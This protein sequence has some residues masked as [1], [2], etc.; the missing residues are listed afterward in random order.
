[1]NWQWI[2]TSG[3]TLVM[4]FVSG[5]GTYAALLTLT[6]VAGL[7]SFSKMSGFDFATTV[8]FGSILASTLL[9]KDPPVASA[10]FGLVLLYGLQ[11]TVSKARQFS[12]RIQRL[13]DNEPLLLMAGTRIITENMRTARVTEDDLRSKLRLAG[14]TDRR[15]VLAVVFE[16]TGDCAVLREGDT[17]DPWLLTKVRGAEHLEAE[18]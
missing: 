8:A 7:R 16:T 3:T 6:R 15:Q 11:Y 13:V 10:V 1:M 14:V 17:L 12:P 2:S 18:R 9:S 5:I 4:V